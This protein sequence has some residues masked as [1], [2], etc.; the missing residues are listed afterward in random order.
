MQIKAN[1]A[2]LAAA[3][4][5]AWTQ[6]AEVPGAD[7]GKKLTV[8]ISHTTEAAEPVAR[9]TVTAQKMFAEI[10][11]DL[12]W[13]DG[14][15]FCRAHPQQAILVD[16]VAD[17]PKTQPAA[18]AYALPFE[19]QH[20]QVFYNRI[21]RG[22]TTQTPSLLAH[23][24]VH[25]IAHMLQGLDRH[26]ETGIMKAHWDVDEYRSME[27]KP[28]TFTEEDVRLIHRGLSARMGRPASNL[29]AAHR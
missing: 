4:M 22:N 20:I 1:L 16:V 5:T 28:L 19:G 6:P 13:H 7:S 9:A 2:A 18:L 21:N 14:A 23:V 12:I 15:R 27:T 17:A 25:E 11:V 8:C 26:S 29:L 3:G 24:L 10:G